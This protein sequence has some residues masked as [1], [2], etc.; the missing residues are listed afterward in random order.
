VRGYSRSLLRGGISIEGHFAHGDWF[1]FG[2]DLFGAHFAKGRKPCVPPPA[3]PYGRASGSGAG[4]WPGRLD[5][6]A[7][8]SSKKRCLTFS[9]AVLPTCRRLV[10]VSDESTPGELDADGTPSG[11]NPQGKQI[12]EPIIAL[13]WPYPSWTQTPAAH[14]IGRSRKRVPREPT[15]R[16]Q[17]HS[18]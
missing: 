3:L 4:V 9:D 2:G 11:A 15:V 14:F 8:P 5:T 7:R 18:N 16:T 1:L 12:E 6:E 10:S 13:S 17:L